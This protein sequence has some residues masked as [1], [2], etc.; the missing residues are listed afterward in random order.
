MVTTS[1][2]ALTEL[3][4]VDPIQDARIPVQSVRAEHREG[5]DGAPVY[6]LVTIGPTRGDW[7][8]DGAFHVR[9]AVRRRAAELGLVDDV[10]VVLASADPDEQPSD[11]D[12]G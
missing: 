7:D 6:V 5:P 3:S 11:E 4:Q 12:Q 8:L 1:E 2:S 9:Q 10:V